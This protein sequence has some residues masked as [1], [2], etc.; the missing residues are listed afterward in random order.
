ME[1]GL[2]RKIDIDNEMQQA[3]LD[4]AMSV[5]VARALPDARD[6][7][8]PVQ[9]RI[10]YAMYDMGIRADSPYKKSARIVGE[11]LG[12]YHPHGDSAVYEAMARLAQDFSMRTLLVD[13]QGN[14]GS[15]DGDPPAAMRYTE[16]RLTS[17]AL[18]ILFDLNKNTVDFNPNFD[19]TLTE[20]S[21]LPAALP[22]LLVNGATG[23]AVGMATSIPPHNLGEVID[24]LVYM[25]E[26]WEKLD[27]IDVETLMEFI[28]GPDFPTGGLIIQEKGEDGLEAAYGSGRGRVIVQA[29]A[30]VEEMER[31]KNRIIVTELPY[32]V[33][34]S[35]LIERIADLAREGHLDGLSDLRDE[36]DRHGMRIVLEMTKNADPEVI[37]RDL[38]KRTPM[39]TTFSI[40]LLALVDGEPRTL[41]LKQ[42]LR[43]Y[44]EHRLTVIKRRAEFELERARQ[45]AHILEGYLVALKNLDEVINIIRSASD[46][47]TARGKL[48]KRFKLTE[49][50]ATA[51]LDLQLRRLAALERRKIETEYREVTALIKDLEN[52]LKSPKRMRGVVAHELLK[53]K[54]QYGDRRRTQI[55][56]I[57]GNGQAAK[58]LTAR[59]LLPEQQVWIGVTEEGLVSRTH[60]DKQPRQSG[61]DAPRWLVKTST[62]DTVYFVSKSGR[63]A[64]V[65]AHILPQTDKLSQGTLFHRVTPLTDN[66]SLAAVFALPSRKAVLPEETSVVTAT[67]MGMIKKSLVSE[68]P[69]PSSQTFVLVRVNE[70]DRLIEVGLT[71]NKT[72]DILLVTAQGM[73]IRFKEEEVRPMGLVAAGVNGLKLNDGDEVVGMEILPADGEIF[74]ITSEGKAK[75]VEQKEFPVQG[76]YG[77]GVIAWDLPEKARLAGVAA[78]KPNHM[79]T[80]HLTKGAPKSTR[81][82]EAGIRKRAATK[83]DVIVDVKPGE[84]VVSVN[85]GWT[86]EKFVSVPNGRANGHKSSSPKGKEDN[87]NKNAKL[88]ASANGKAKTS[89]PKSKSAVKKSTPK[90][91]SAARKSASR[92]KTT[93][94][95]KKSSAKKKK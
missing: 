45:R 94:P 29:K 36:S 17:A 89:S 60:D 6:G 53:V 39:Q 42:A 88:K 72:K 35:S 13:G 22:N 51:I 85:V 48:M 54:D 11:V 8:K 75:R 52:L 91:K 32:M 31:G 30:H 25:L 55:I 23:I 71:D 61:N 49:I 26:K 57:S 82:D 33:N 5:I 73:A 18:D 95:A 12:K 69:G 70:G 37:L 40:N 58:T 24:A 90:G 34:K 15:V 64:A 92:V 16:A 65:A 63:A 62:T 46:V 67:K 41:T 4:Y 1:L 76:R 66:D 14:F 74:L 50:Q 28:Q 7:L 84:E 38:Y 44:I 86:V 80:I 20:P 2:I 93:K 10:L 83:G 68:L 77:R 78:D 87:G 47:D 3:Y 19:D 27:D 9:R 56:N 21:V 79:A 81:L 43:V 59:D